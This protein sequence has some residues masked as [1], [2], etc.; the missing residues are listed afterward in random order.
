LSQA[1]AN[2]RIIDFSH[3]F[4]GPFA[5]N[6]LCLMGADVIKIEAPER[7]DTMRYYGLERDYDG[8]SPAFISI[9]SGKRAITLDLKTCDG[10]ESARK[11]IATADV[12]VENFRPGVMERLG[13]GYADCRAI[14]PKI[15]FCSISGFGQTGGLSR[16]PALDQIIQSLSGLM[17]V[18]GEADE[19]PMR[20]GFPIVDTFSGAMAAFAIA[21]ALLQRERFGVGQAIDL[22]MLDSAMVMM[23][24]IVGPYLVT[25]RR[26]E[27]TG[28]RGYSLAPTA[29]TFPTADGL[30]TLAVIQDAHFKKFC[31]EIGRPELP[32]DSRFADRWKRIANGSALCEAVKAALSTR[33]ALDWESR[34][35]RAGLP[36]AAVREIPE[37]IAHAHFEGSGLKMPLHVPELPNPNVTVLGT[38]F[39]FAHDGPTLQGPPPRHGE[40]TQ[41][42]LNELSLERD[43]I[44]SSRSNV[45]E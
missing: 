15:I 34:L 7:G 1:F 37:A 39:R 36:A 8:L 9:N 27:R 16:N 21:A 6:L 40:H 38:G 26:P 20:V 41:E 18:S 28:N 42:I 5:T 44:G 30:L 45:M 19:A 23:T 11:L 31:D 35:T 43:D 14:Q 29:D 4:S 32:F 17:C 13:L 33:S 12:V 10:I 3:V 2:Y 25:G 24:S 22:S